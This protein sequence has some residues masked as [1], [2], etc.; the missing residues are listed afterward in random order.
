M[1]EDEMVRWHHRF[2]GCEFEKTPGDCEG[3]GDLA[4]CRPWG[5][6][7]SKEMTE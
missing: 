6:K 4:C 7:V 3:Q 1:P 5:H 2:G